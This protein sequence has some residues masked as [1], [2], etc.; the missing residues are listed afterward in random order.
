M[1]HQSGEMKECLDACQSC[2]V[3][4][5]SMLTNHCVQVGGAHVAPD[6]VQIMLDCIQICATSVDFMARGSAHHR[7]ICRECAEVCRSCAA[8]CG[9]LDGMDECVAACL[10]CAEA[11]EKMA[12]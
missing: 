2:H 1:Q 9:K 12:A 6:H 7:H 8:S 3:T 11:C 5:L 10:R 4:C